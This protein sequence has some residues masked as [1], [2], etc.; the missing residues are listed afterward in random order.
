MSGLA[1][2]CQLRRLGAEVAV[3]EAASAAGGAVAT[4]RRDGWVAESGPHLVGE[5]PVAIAETVEAGGGVEWVAPL[6]A[7]RRTFVFFTDR[8]VPVPGSIAELIDS[9]LLSVGGRLRMV[10]ER[11]EPRGGSSEETVT[12]F[13]RRRFGDEVASRIFD[14]LARSMSGGDPDRLLARFLFPAEVEYEQT[15]GSVLKGRARARMEA[16]RRARREGAGGGGLRAPRDG[17]GR[18]PEAIARGLGPAFRPGC[19]VTAVAVDGNELVVRCGELAER[20][21]AA[22]LAVPPPAAALI[23]GGADGGAVAH[24]AAMPV[25]QMVAVSLGFHHDDVPRLSDGYRILVPSGARRPSVAMTMPCS[26]FP[27]RAPDGHLLL[28]LHLSADMPDDD[29]DAVI[30]VARR[31]AEALAGVTRPPRFVAVGSWHAMPQP[32]PGHAAHLAAAD[33]LEER[34][35]G[36]VLCGAWRDGVAVADTM[37]G[38]VAAATRLAA[39]LGWTGPAAA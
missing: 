39:R 33:Q 27:D 32:V 24:L 3:F 4:E 30:A 19:R 21:D 23:A 37:R 18:L 6:P 9:A 28:T 34:I 20:V 14:P 11:F 36:L 25:R 7:V 38:G 10:R 8:V 26:L 22:V 15:V 13:A 5:L 1:A 31:D 35:P 2:A 29:R 12:A 16:R 17:M